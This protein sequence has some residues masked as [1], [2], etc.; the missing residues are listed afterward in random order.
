MTLVPLQLCRCEGNTL[1]PMSD[2]A[3][4]PPADEAV[5]EVSSVAQRIGL[6]PYGL[7]LAS[8]D[9]P[10]LVVSSMGAQSVGKSYQVSCVPVAGGCRW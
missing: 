2:G 7:V 3:P 1:L 4:M 5:L 10:V 9:M 6:G 8:L